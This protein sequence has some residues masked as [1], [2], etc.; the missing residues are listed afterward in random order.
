V[1][2]KNAQRMLHRGSMSLKAGR[3]Q[4][5]VQRTQPNQH[6]RPKLSCG[7]KQIVGVLLLDDAS[8]VVKDCV[9]QMGAFR[10]VNQSL[11]LFLS[12]SEFQRV[13]PAGMVP[14]SPL[15]HLEAAGM[16]SKLAEKQRSVIGMRETAF[17]AQSGHTGVAD[18]PVDHAKEA[19]HL[20]NRRVVLNQVPRLQPIA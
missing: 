10:E 16:K 4:D 12:E 2:Q 11:L 9:T 6:I 5:R 20:G 18:F 1:M 13:D 17:V 3:N 19:M 7:F 15:L 14:R 8:L